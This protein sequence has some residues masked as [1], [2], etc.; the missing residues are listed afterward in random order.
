MDF[1]G[2]L[3]REIFSTGSEW[4]GEKEEKALQMSFFGAA[5]KRVAAVSSFPL[6]AHF[7]KKKQLMEID[8]CLHRIKNLA[9][10]KSI[11]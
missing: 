1:R 8:R 2:D 11:Y 5:K 4:V 9:A 7:E 3:G 6:I 10:S